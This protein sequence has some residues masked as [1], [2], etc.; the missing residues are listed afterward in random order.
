MVAFMGSYA[1]VAWL[2]VIAWWLGRGGEWFLWL[3]T[4]A[5]ALAVAAFVWR[6]V[7]IRRTQRSQGSF[8]EV[9]PDESPQP[10]AEPPEAQRLDD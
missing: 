6:D 10:S 7:L 8:R 4:A 9:T 5:F 2:G 3:R 1:L